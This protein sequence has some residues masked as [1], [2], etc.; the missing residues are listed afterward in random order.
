MNLLWF[1]IL[2]SEVSTDRQNCDEACINAI[3]DPVPPRDYF[4]GI[5]WALVAIDAIPLEY[6]TRNH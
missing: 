1:F 4:F 3:I 5:C 2:L 6:V